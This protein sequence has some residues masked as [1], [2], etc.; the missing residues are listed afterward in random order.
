VRIQ[1]DILCPTISV[2]V[3][4]FFSSKLIRFAN[5]QEFSVS[6]SEESLLARQTAAA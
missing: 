2:L 3:S 6:D 4:C 1:A 5:L